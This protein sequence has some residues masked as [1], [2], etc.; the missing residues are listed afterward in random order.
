MKRTLTVLLC[1]ILAAM[2]PCVCAASAENGAEGKLTFTT[3]D[4][5]GAPVDESMMS[6]YELVF[7]NFWEPWC[8]PCMEELPELEKAYEALKEEGI[9]FIGVTNMV[10]VPDLSPEEVVEELGI[11]YPVINFS[12]DFMFIVR[13]G[14]IE[15]PTSVIVGKDGKT[16]PLT[17]EEFSLLV[18]HLFARLAEDCER[19]GEREAAEEYRSMANA[20]SLP[21]A[22][23][24]RYARER[25]A[26]T[27]SNLDREVLTELFRSVRERQ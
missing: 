20:A 18:R 21:E 10:P 19:A 15:I 7:I 22:M 24:N 1:V 14:M 8:G 2:L 26:F 17:T 13:D 11:S 9:L 4:L 25:G 3:T 5:N 16:V 27:I 23:L 12:N 6:G